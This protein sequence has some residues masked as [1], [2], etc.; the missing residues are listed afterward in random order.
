MAG[1]KKGKTGQ[2]D[3]KPAPKVNIV[4]S[5]DCEKCRNQCVTG[6]RY[7]TNLA[8]RGKGNGVVCKK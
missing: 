6:K 4:T 1:V 8:I 3:K 7:L 2:S 5:A